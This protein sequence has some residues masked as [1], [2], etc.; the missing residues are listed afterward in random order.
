M[1]QHKVFVCDCGDVD[2]NMIIS[3]YDGF[4]FVNVHISNK[5]SLWKRVKYALLLLVG[6]EP[7]FGAYTELVLNEQQLNE[8]ILTLQAPETNADF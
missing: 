3:K 4:T 2:H 1:T 8:L 6:K 7:K 5:M